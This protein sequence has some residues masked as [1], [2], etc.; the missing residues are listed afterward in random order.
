MSEESD[1]DGAWIFVSHSNKDLKKVREIRDF[2]EREGHKP[3]LFYL[4]CLE[5][6]NARLP[7][8]IK[9][10]I[11]A[12]T[13][14][15]LCDSDNAKNSNW[16]QE[17][18]RIV[19]AMEDKSRFYVTV[20]LARDI[21]AQR[22]KLALLSKRATVFLSYAR[23]DR[24]IAEQIYHA[25]SKQDY[26]VFFD[27]ESIDPGMHWAGTITSALEDAMDR[28]FVLLLLSNDYLTSLW[29]AHERSYAF[30]VLGSRPN[31]I[32]PVIIKDR[33]QVVAGLPADLQRI[34]YVDFTAG[35]LRANIDMLLADLKTRRMV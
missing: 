27:V 35:D 25:L 21:D 23:P 14:F 32:V 18:R 19:E 33:A 7:Q 5:T 34:Q 13:W 29:C 8:L 11:E 2:L 10:E 4:R 15:V 22:D 3:L 6:D 28:G 24:E 9:D 26:R 20:D 30:E 1:Q 31:N 16:V 12:R 17:E